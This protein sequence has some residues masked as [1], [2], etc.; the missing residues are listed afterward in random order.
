MQEGLVSRIIR[1]SMANKGFVLFSVAVLAFFS[2]R[3]M[4]EAPIDALPDL[5]ET[6]VIVFAEWMGRSPELVEDQI[7]YPV[8]AS[9]RSAPRVKGVRGYS[10][11]GMSFIYVIFEEGTDI[12]WARSRVLEYLEG[13]KGRL[14]KDA[15][16][17]LGPDATGLGW[18]FQ[19]ALV[20]KTGKRSLAELR[21]IQDYY[22]R[23][24][25]QQVEGV[26]EVA[27]IGGFEKEYQV[28]VDPVAL[29][30]TGISF[31]EVQH[32]ISEANRDV[33]GKI[34]E[35]AG[36]EYFI[37]GRGYIKGVEDIENL[38]IK[39]HKSG[40][41][42]RVRDVAKVQIGGEIRRGASDI[43]GE[44]EAVSGIVV[45]RIG[46]NPY[47]VIEG[48]KKKLEEI[49]DGLGEGL[50]IKVVYDRSGL[51]ERSLNTL[52]RALLQEG[53]VVA[54]V[55]ILFL[56]H[57]RS[58]LVPIIVLGCA[59]LLCFL[60]L[61]LAGV[62]NNIMSLGG[63]AIA[64]GAMVDSAIVIIEN[65]HKRL[66]GFT[67]SNHE[68]SRVLFESVKEV[69]PSIFF[70][71][72]ITAVSFLPVF[73]LTGEAGK[74]FRPLALTKTLAMVLAALLSITL[75]PATIGYAVRGRIRSE[76]KHPVSKALIAVYRPFIQVAL[77][78]PLSTVLIGVLLVGSTILVI[79][80]LGTEFMPPLNE[81]DIL[82]MPTTL[83]NISVEEAK[84][85]LRIQD[86]LIKEV[87]EV[88][89][90]YGKAG[91]STSPT[92]PA[93]ISMVETVIKLKPKEKWRK[94]KVKRFY[95][96]LPSSPVRDLLAY[97]FPEERSITFEEIVR[98]L[99]AKVR[100]PGWT[101]AWTMPIRARIDM[102][103]TGVRTPVGIKVL[104][105]D[106][107]TLEEVAI[108]IEKM[109]A[110]MKGSRGVFAE[111]SFGGMYVDVVPKLEALSRYG[112]KQEDVLDFV[113][114]Q[115]GGV[116]V[117][118]TVEG[119]GRFSI[120]VR[121]PRDVR[122]DP[123]SLGKVL[124]PLQNGSYVTL[125]ELAEIS[126]QE[127]PS[128]IK[129]EDGL[130]AVYVFVDVDESVISLGEFVDHAKQAVNASLGPTPG[131]Y[132]Q[133]TG[134]YEV[135]EEMKEN[136]KILVPLSIFLVI[137]L[138]YLHYR[139]FAHVLII[140]ATVPFALVGSFWL[141]HILDYRLSAAVWVGIISM[142]GLAAET[143]IVM[144]VYLDHEFHR[145]KALGQIKSLE[146]IVEAHIAGAVERVRPKMMTVI[147][148]FTGLLPLM[149]ATG[150]GADVMKRIAAPMVGGLVTSA[151]LT[152]E[153][154]PV[155]MT[156]YRYFQ[157]KRR[158]DL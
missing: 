51:I 36:R 145:R 93:P 100:L 57:I 48:V 102:L 120:S 26:A 138:L 42:V 59:V 94:K 140:L 101:N 39:T 156:Y 63:I 31:H 22:I 25:L 56:L 41:P 96:E 114:Q 67:G 33:G 99:D 40:A 19:Y 124:F 112:L 78:W 82:Y 106:L 108:K 44:G 28:V 144:V 143:G 80:R 88:E 68:R 75:L 49:K 3:A 136:M 110:E 46:A 147:T 12:Y 105:S 52:R 10:M 148:S 142:V 32:T 38:V 79:K 115:I 50:E 149:W 15:V 157:L 125:Q 64:I 109:L 85:V 45:A 60:P 20:D 123:S 95:S 9:L 119:R 89:V 132:L 65:T 137:L 81:G 139:S 17:T 37:R 6:Q 116:T 71:L 103:T 127:G 27:S 126:V 113:E 11:F 141:L 91:K 43:D 24:A 154:L 84:R 30:A 18:V 118:E 131:V 62:T 76:S 14:P 134:Q 146:D 7:T 13:I 16:I 128:M 53:L 90:V 122:E 47:K 34:M 70:A 29:L 72:L 152:L 1:L 150:S 98:E 107:K 61:Y 111:R 104:G 135:M 2:Y 73:G 35:V 86:K 117:S 74:L 153:I 66:E 87:P 69:A 77:R 92:D 5:T 21:S 83:P 130:L 151:F 121:Y 58:S 54:I 8:V 133:W 55:I 4:K 155:L 97:L 158:G 129:N 23:Y